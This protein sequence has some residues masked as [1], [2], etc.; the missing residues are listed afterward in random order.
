MAIASP[1]TAISVGE[2]ARVSPAT[3]LEYLPADEQ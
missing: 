3:V 2:P 1:G